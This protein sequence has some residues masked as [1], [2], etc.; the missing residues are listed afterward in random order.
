MSAPYHPKGRCTVEVGT[1]WRLRD[2]CPARVD[3]VV[4]HV[5]LWRGRA[6]AEHAVL[7]LD[8]D[9]RAGHIVGHHRGDADAEIDKQPPLPGPPIKVARNRPSYAL[10][11]LLFRYDLHLSPCLW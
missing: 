8:E 10:L 9:A 7:G 2:A 11:G 6:N 3:K 4:V 5:P 1:S